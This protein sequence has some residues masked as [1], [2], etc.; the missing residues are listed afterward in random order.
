MNPD[1][2]THK[3]QEALQEAQ[4]HALANGQQSVESW[5]L[6]LVLVEQADGVVRP[7]LDKIGVDVGALSAELVSKVQSLPKVQGGQPYVGAT[8]SGL[9][10]A[11]QAHADRLQDDYLST[12]HLL[13]AACAE[14]APTAGLLRRHGVN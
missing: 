6:L 14:Q 7:L 10:T 4:R 9:L 11:G 3:A 2:M 12:E 8:L 5:H 13:L 1:K